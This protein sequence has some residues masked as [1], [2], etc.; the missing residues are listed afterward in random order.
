VISSYEIAKFTW[1]RAE[2]RCGSDSCPSRSFGYVKEIYHTRIGEPY[3][4]EW[5]H[6]T[7]EVQQRFGIEIPS[8]M[9]PS[10][11]KEREQWQRNA[12]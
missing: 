11:V 6:W 8:W 1:L 5:E 7:K 2:I 10:I 9:T 4:D 12:P 3:K